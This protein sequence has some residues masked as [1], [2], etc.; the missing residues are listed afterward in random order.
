MPKYEVSWIKTY[1]AADYV[2]IEANSQKEA[3]DIARKNI[4]NYEGSIHHDDTKDVVFA[5]AVVEELS[6]GFTKKRILQ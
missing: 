2:E 5:I 3:E 1:Y 6:P 4:G